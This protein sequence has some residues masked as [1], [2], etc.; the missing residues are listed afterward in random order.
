MIHSSLSTSSKQSTKIRET[1]VQARHHHSQPQHVFIQI[2]F[3]VCPSAI[4]S[5]LSWPSMTLKWLRRILT[6]GHQFICYYTLLPLGVSGVCLQKYTH[7]H[8]GEEHDESSSVWRK[9]FMENKLISWSPR[10]KHAECVDAPVLRTDSLWQTD[11]H[12]KN[13]VEY[14]T[15]STGRIIS[16]FTKTT[17]RLFTV[18]EHDPSRNDWMLLLFMYLLNFQMKWI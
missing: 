15:I 13:T 10:A 14:I 2:Y 12:F 8:A 9:E 4:C 5:L 18:P 6:S 7:P 1:N 17:Q 3:T 11:T 16:P